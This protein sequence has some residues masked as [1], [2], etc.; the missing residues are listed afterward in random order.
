MKNAKSSAPEMFCKRILLSITWDFSFFYFLFYKE[1]C[2]I[3][4]EF[5]S[6]LYGFE[7]QLKRK[8][9]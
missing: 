4:L 2:S 6:H 8:T 3:F 1:T 9:D 7:C 5:C